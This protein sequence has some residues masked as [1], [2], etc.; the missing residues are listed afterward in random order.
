MPTS[1]IVFIAV[2]LCLLVTVLVVAVCVYLKMQ[3]QARDADF[4]TDLGG[5]GDEYIE[6]FSPTPSLGSRAWAAP[7]LD[8]ET[9]PS[10]V[11]VQEAAVQAAVPTRNSAMADA[12]VGPPPSL[13][14]PVIPTT[15]RSSL[16]P[17]MISAPQPEQGTAWLEPSP[18]RDMSTPALDEPSQNK[19]KTQKLLFH[20][21]RAMTHSIGV[22]MHE[23]KDLNSSHGHLKPRTPLNLAAAPRL[24]EQSPAIARLHAARNQMQVTV[25]N[26][27]DAVEEAAVTS[28]FQNKTDLD[29]LVYDPAYMHIAQGNATDV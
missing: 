10:K 20:G 7:T 22:A 26:A 3:K 13:S 29:D 16:G 14:A 2:V 23:L 12:S 25:S 11:V 9:S 17:V 18:P 4:T 24:R 6:D 8:V 1:W 19:A 28:P 5:P 15:R 21:A 27:Y